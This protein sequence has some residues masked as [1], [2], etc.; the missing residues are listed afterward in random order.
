MGRGFLAYSRF[1]QYSCLSMSRLVLDGVQN[2][3]ARDS[4]GS[5]GAAAEVPHREPSSV[6][7]ALAKLLE[8][9]GFKLF[10]PHGPRVMGARHDLAGGGVRGR[11]G[12]AT[13]SLAARAA[14]STLRS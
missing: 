6:S 12:P 7:G 1:F 5:F 4:D 13:A 2:M 9:L 8:Q 11:S 10:T 14:T 3:D